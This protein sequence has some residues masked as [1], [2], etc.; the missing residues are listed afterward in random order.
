M[1][2]DGVDTCSHFAEDG[3]LVAAAGA[4]FKNGHGGL[5][6]EELGLPCYGVGFGDG[7][8]AVDFD[9]TVDVVEEIVE[10]GV[11]A[12]PLSRQFLHGVEETLVGDAALAQLFDHLASP[13][14]VFG[15]VDCHR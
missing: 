7:L 1:A 2:F 3:G 5:E 6:F 9:G 15:R 11:G 13:G 8:V 12:E 14:F 10:K 4:Y